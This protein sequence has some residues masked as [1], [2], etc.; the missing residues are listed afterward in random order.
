MCLFPK[1]N[2]LKMCDKWTMSELLLFLDQR[3]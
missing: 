1:E 2:E 3:T